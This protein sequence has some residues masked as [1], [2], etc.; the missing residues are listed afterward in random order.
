MV[1]W[2]TILIGG[3]LVA[4]FVYDV[5]KGQ[6]LGTSLKNIGQAIGDVG[7]GFQTFISSIWS[8]QIKPTFLPTIG[9]QWY[10][11]EAPK[12]YIPKTSSPTPLTYETPSFPG[13]VTPEIE[14]T[15]RYYFLP[16]LEEGLATYNV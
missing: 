7:K 5:I 11:G 4:P 15:P 16:R 3:V 8:P 13:Q 12:G 9:F 6:P 10:F 1:S 14:E 2:K